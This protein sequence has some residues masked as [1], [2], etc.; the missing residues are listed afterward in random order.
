MLL[1]PLTIDQEGCVRVPDRPGFGLVLDEERI[2]RYTVS[3][4]TSSVKD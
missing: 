2:A 1:E 4:H 3:T